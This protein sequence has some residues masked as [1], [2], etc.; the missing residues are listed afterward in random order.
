[1]NMSYKFFLPLILLTTTLLPAKTGVSNAGFP[2]NTP[3]EDFSPSITADGKTMVFDSRL[4]QERAHNIYI[5]QFSQGKWSKPVYMEEL[6]SS[7][8]DET[9]YILPDGS[10][11]V[12]ASD[13]PSSLR[14]AVTSDGRE[15]ITYDIYISYRRGHTWTAPRIIPGDVNT[16]WNERAPSLSADRKYLY[17]S[18]WPFKRMHESVIMVA[19]F[20]D[21]RYEKA[22][23]LPD[24]IN[25]GAYETAFVPSRQ[26]NGFYFSSRRS[27]SRG[28]W[29]LFFIEYNRGRYGEVLHLGRDINSI[30]NE[31]FASEQGSQLYF[32]SNR[33]GGKGQFDIWSAPLPAE[34]SRFNRNR[35]TART[36]GVPREVHSGE[37]PLVQ[38][39]KPKEEM[40]SPV[41]PAE[42]GWS[43]PRLVF[44]VRD[45]NGKPL[46]ALFTIEL[47]GMDSGKPM[48][49]TERKSCE[50][51]L[52]VVRPKQDVRSLKIVFNEKGFKPFSR[53]FDIRSLRRGRI[54]LT[55]ERIPSA[56]PEKEHT[57]TEE[58][59]ELRPIYYADKG[60]DIP[61]E[62]YPLLDRLAE[63]MKIHTN[64]T[65][66]ID[67]HTDR[68]GSSS[69][70]M[71]ISRERCEKVKE[72]LT[73][74][75]VP[76]SQ[77][78]TKGWGETS[79][80]VRGAIPEVQRV[81]RRVELTLTH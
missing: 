33:P 48:R 6:N 15:R 57:A 69:S 58:P 81:N 80:R 61:A 55:I 43:P 44:Q 21:G 59:P 76:A 73:R 66:R 14:P 40:A 75:G 37:N 62:Y 30:D 46:R 1:M 17:F 8:N 18:R 71:A 4:E 79:P 53:R 23:A 2:I 39:T 32:S 42:A 51:G 27:G 16:S 24:V 74:K 78:T 67:G 12:F 68:R 22:V 70:N 10:A 49:T 72:Y 34:L 3:G 11:I 35:T 45:N 25:S 77:I 31:F 9:P 19:E 47:Y 38:P 26:L 29:D 28:G 60:T 56:I 7:W 65:I 64:S 52:F 20:H 41:K 13:R 54:P 5:S 50:K 36:N 63:W